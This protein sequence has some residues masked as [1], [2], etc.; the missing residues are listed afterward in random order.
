MQKKNAAHERQLV[1]SVNYTLHLPPTGQSI[2]YKGQR[3]LPNHETGEYAKLVE[4]AFYYFYFRQ[5]PSR[6]FSAGVI[7]LEIIQ[8]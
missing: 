4:V 2:N 8:N 7:G 6:T 5:V 1:F 3:L